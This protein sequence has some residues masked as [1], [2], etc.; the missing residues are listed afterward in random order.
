MIISPDFMN[1]DVHSKI[2]NIDTLAQINSKLIY[3]V[4]WN[5]KRNELILTAAFLSTSR[6][7]ATH[8]IETDALTS[9]GL[10]RAKNFVI[11]EKSRTFTNSH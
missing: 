4:V 9:K 6:S 8:I 11:L 3:I 7:G 2:M 10:I 5:N 1:Y